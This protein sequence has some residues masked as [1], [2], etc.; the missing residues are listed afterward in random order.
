MK[1]TQAVRALTAL[2]QIT[3]LEIF[4]LLVRAGQAGVSVG[5]IGEKLDVPGPTLSFHLKELV[6]ADLIAA[7]QEGRF[8][9]YSACFDRMNDLL[10]F[11]TEN[12]CGGNRS[13]CG[14]PAFGPKRKV[15]PK[16]KALAKKSVIARSR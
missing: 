5:Q 7:R 4:R 14:V 16:S 6:N 9:F 8:I 13:A 2:A 10:E 12:C 15:T 3:R 11:L 1:P